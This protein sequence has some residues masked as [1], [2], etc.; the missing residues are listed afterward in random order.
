MNKTYAVVKS[1][2]SAAFLFYN[3]QAKRKKSNKINKTSYIITNPRT[4]N[5]AKKMDSRINAT[6][7]S[8]M[9][10]MTL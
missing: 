3:K 2:A 8:V 1:D 4:Q 5:E 6:Q 10:V 9:S 7:V